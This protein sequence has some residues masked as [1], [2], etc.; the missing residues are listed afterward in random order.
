MR[1]GRL[2]RSHYVESFPSLRVHDAGKDGPNGLP[3]P[4]VTVHINIPLDRNNYSNNATDPKHQAIGSLEAG[5]DEYKADD[6]VE[7]SDDDDDES[8]EG[9]EALDEGE[10][11]AVGASGS[12]S[13]DLDTLRA[14]LPTANQ[15]GLSILGSR[16]QLV[17]EH[18]QRKAI[19][20]W[21]ANERLRHKREVPGFGGNN[22]TWNLDILLAVYD[23][24]AILPEELEATIKAGVEISMGTEIS[25]SDLA[26]IHTLCDQ[27][28]SISEYHAQLSEYL[29]NRMIAIAP[30]LTALVGEL[31]GTR[32]I[33]HAGS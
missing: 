28:I 15:Q 5:E 6:S 8:V 23:F 29:R 14:L 10:D 13:N 31:V 3:Y 7:T 4:L 20:D 26:H 22:G 30:N 12:K 16:G 1:V 19:V 32:L 33:S 11:D 25:E 2:T 18:R 17:D 9:L 27:V 21:F 24:A